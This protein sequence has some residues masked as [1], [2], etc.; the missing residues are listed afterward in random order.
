MKYDQQLIK[1]LKYELNKLKNFKQYQKEALSILEQ[2]G[3]ENKQT[4]DKTSK[5]Q[6]SKME[7]MKRKRIEFI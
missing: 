7:K 4:V 6:H 2:I 3:S 1:P 5:K